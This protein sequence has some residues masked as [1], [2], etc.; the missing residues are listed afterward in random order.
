MKVLDLKE[1]FEGLLNADEPEETIDFSACAVP[2]ELNINM[3]PPSREELDRAIGH[4][5][6]NKA[7]GINK[8]TSEIL[9]DGGEAIR[10]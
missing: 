1:Y 9:K 10:G 5:K 6:Q 7:P 2:E 3:E 4:L 8:I